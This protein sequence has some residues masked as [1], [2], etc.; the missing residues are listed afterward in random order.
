MS[1]EYRNTLHTVAE[2]IRTDADGQRQDG[3][4]NPN[5]G[6]GQRGVDRGADSRVQS[7]ILLSQQDLESLWV[8]NWLATRIVQLVV[9]ESLLRGFRID[10]VDD[11]KAAQRRWMKLNYAKY[12]EGALQRAQYQARLYG[13]GGLYIGT[14]GASGATTSPLPDESEFEIGFLETFHAFTLEAE[15]RYEGKNDANFRMPKI[16]KTTGTFRKDLRFHETR[17]LR[18]IGVPPMNLNQRAENSDEYPE[19]GLSVLQPVFNE[20]SRYDLSWAALSNL[21]Q[22]SSIPIFTIKGLAGSVARKGLDVL[23]NRFALFNSGR[24][25]LKSIVLEEGEEYRREAVSFADLPGVFQQLVIAVS[26]AAGIPV[27]K[28]FKQSPAGMNATGQSDLEQWND[29]VNVYRELCLRPQL[30]QLIGAIEKKEVEISFP[31]M[32]APSEKDQAATRLTNAQADRAY[33]EMEAMDAETLVAAR[34]EGKN[35]EDTKLWAAGPPEKEP[36]PPPPVPILPPAPE[37][38]GSGH[39]TG[40]DED[41]D[42]EDEGQS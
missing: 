14:K 22:E 7:G 5:T 21:L 1:D 9:D 34:A 24:S 11:A 27:T 23:R 16:Y 36:P 19:W 26:A 8:C 32:S 35:P 40:G 38:E 3:I 6:L 41:P 4:Y 13:G 29:T 18:T 10:G 28:L 37:T 33:W 12:R 2:L 39:E 15:T 42:D 31:P 25:L 30:E 17:F 20:L